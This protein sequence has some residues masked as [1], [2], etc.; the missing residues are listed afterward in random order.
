[1]LLFCEKHSSRL[2]YTL[3][4]IFQERLGILYEIC[5]DKDAFQS[6]NKEKIIYSKTSE[7]SNADII[8]IKSTDFLYSKET[9]AIENDTADFQDISLPFPTT[10]SSFSIDPFANIFFHLSRYEEYYCDTTDNHDRFLA[11]KSHAFK[12]DYLQK[13]VVDRII[14]SLKEIIKEKYPQISLK[15]ENYS[16]TPSYDIDMAFAY[17]HK[18]FLINAAGFLSSLLSFN[19]KDISE[20]FRVLSN[21]EKD[22]FDSFDYILEQHKRR[23]LKGIF[24]I[25]CG[26]KRTAYDKSISLRKTAIQ[27]LLKTLQK[28]NEIGLHPSYFSLEKAHLIKEEKKELEKYLQEKVSKTRFHYLRFDVKKSF[29]DLEHAGITTDYS[30][31]YASEPGFRAG[32]SRSFPWYDLKNEKQS[33]IR[34]QPFSIMDGSLKDYL[35]LDEK[36]SKALIEKIITEIKETQG[37]FISLWH[38]ESLS[39]KR[40]WEKWLDVY[41]FLLD[42]AKDD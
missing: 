31:C 9:T 14:I 4:Y 7:S 39:N 24:F 41:S 27:E 21:K 37:V 16:F 1:M 6:S 32:T 35:K 23:A 13:V 18:G 8:Y 29:R 26:N 34:I 20:R 30:M 2:K 3:D 22:P 33:N 12:N 42:K 11:E 19:F 38:N 40:R 17:K 25:H 36:E 10:S 15:E 5:H 28:D